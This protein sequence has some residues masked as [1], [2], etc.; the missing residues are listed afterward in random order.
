[1]D[2]EISIDDQVSYDPILCNVPLCIDKVHLTYLDRDDRDRR[3][4]TVTEKIEI[5]V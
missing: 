2:I 4:A 1:M 5:A 3:G